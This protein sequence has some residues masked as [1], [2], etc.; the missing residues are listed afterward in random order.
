MDFLNTEMSR[1]TFFSERQTFLKVAREIG[2]HVQG[3]INQISICMIR[4]YANFFYL[5]I[6]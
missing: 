4:N 1:A 3:N 6:N 5:M 2:R